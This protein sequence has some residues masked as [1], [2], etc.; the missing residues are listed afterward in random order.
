[1]LGK[2]AVAALAMATAA[3]GDV[4]REGTG[5]RREALD[6]ME[7]TAFDGALWGKLAAWSG[8]EALTPAATGGSVVLICTWS[9][10]YQPS[11][12]QGLPIAQR[13]ADK[14]GGKGLIVVGVHHAQ[15][16]DQAAAAATGAGAKFVLGHDA[17]GE[18]RSALQVDQDPD[19]YIIDRAGHLRYADVATG[20]VE[21]AVAELVGET[22]EQASDL[23]RLLAERGDAARAAAAANV[24]IRTEVELSSLPA[25]PPG[26]DQP[27]D[28]EYTRMFIE[29]M[30]PREA[31]E[32]QTLRNMGLV[33]QDGT[34]VVGTLNIGADAFPEGFDP[35]SAQGRVVV[36]YFWHPDVRESYSV[37]DRMDALQRRHPRD[38][39]VIGACTPRQNLEGPNSQFASGQQ[40]ETVEELERKFKN[41]KR[42][43]KFDHMVIFDPG[44]TAALSWPQNA[45]MNSSVDSPMP[46][47]MIVSSDLAVRF[48]GSAQWSVFQSWLDRIIQLDPG[49]RLRRVLDERYLR[50]RKR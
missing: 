12:R 44:A 30:W 2:M 3:Y 41:F 14:Y 36:V 20:S 31:R 9:S 37:F 24:G 28:T 21:E 4:A 22:K 1:M 10:W 46:R 15:G 5:A 43:R 40:T 13:M 45:G 47:A 6:K 50:D 23:P 25:V 39:L 11:I 35:N 16:W 33:G 8:G 42:T 38:L 17:N 19:F 26:Y 27:E 32:N 18:F 48:F 34:P 29:T 49:V 7:L